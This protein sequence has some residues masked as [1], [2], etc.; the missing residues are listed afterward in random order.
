MLIAAIDETSH[1][2]TRTYH[3][4]A[5]LMDGDGAIDLGKDLDNISRQAVRDYGLTAEVEFHGHEIFHGKG[6]WMPMHDTVRARIALYGAVLEAIS[7]NCVGFY[8]RGVYRDRFATRYAE[9]GYDEHTA[10]MAFLTE[11]IDAHC[12]PQGQRII[13]IADEC[14]K[15]AAVR[16]DLRRFR[17]QGT[18]GYRART[19]TN[20]VDTIHFAPSSESRLIQAVDM[21]AFIYG[22]QMTTTGNPRSLA[23]TAALWR[24]VGS[25]NLNPR[26]VWRP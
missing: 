19:I 5:L 23:A 13:C 26:R 3:V 8:A 22:R 14:G 20:I 21:L 11:E 9:R 7:R 2:P 12:D 10:V 15:Q 18:W 25:M 24:K 16:A 4:L 1:E 6:I 17:D